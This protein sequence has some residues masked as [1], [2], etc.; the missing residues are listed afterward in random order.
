ML[1]YV[2]L[3]CCHLKKTRYCGIELICEFPKQCSLIITKTCFDSFLLFLR[4][5]QVCKS[6]FWTVC[7]RTVQRVDHIQ[8]CS[9]NQLITFQVVATCARACFCVF[10]ARPTFRCKCSSPFQGKAAIKLSANHSLRPTVSQLK[11]VFNTISNWFEN[12]QPHKTKIP[13]VS[14]FIHSKHESNGL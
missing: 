2:A 9:L 4:V 14:L 7:Y 10:G 8:R 12:H 1:R 13:T 5:W 3:K 11:C 6:C